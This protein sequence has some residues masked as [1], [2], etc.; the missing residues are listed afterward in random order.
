MGLLEVGR[1]W[2]G[3]ELAGPKGRKFDLIFGT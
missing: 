1:V 2:C 3:A